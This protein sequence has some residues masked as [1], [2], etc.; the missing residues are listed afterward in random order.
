MSGNRDTSGSFV[1]IGTNGNFWSSVES[2]TN[3]WRRNLNSGNATVNRNTNDKANGFS[4]RCLKDWKISFLSLRVKRNNLVAIVYLAVV[5]KYPSYMIYGILIKDLFRA[6]YDARRNKQSKL[7]V[8]AFELE[9]ESELIR[10]GKELVD[11]TYAVGQSNCFMVFKPSRREIFAANFRDR[12]VQH[13]IFNYINP[14]FDPKFINDSYSCRVGKGTSAGI[15]RCDH[16]IRSCSQNYSQDCFILKMDLRG[17][18]MA[19]NK[20]IL[21]KELE[22]GIVEDKNY[23][24]YDKKWLLSLIRL[25]VFHD[26]TKNC[27]IKN[28]KEDWVGLPKNKS[29]FF[30]GKDRGLPIGNLT[31]QLFANIYLNGFDHYVKEVLKCKYYGRYVDDIIIVNTDKKRL[32]TLIP[33]IKNYLQ[34][35]LMLELHPKKIYLQHYKR[36]VTFLGAVIKPYRKYILNRTKGNF[37]TKIKQWNKLLKLSGNRLEEDELKKFLC[38]TNSYLGLMAQFSTFKLRK[39][40]LTKYLAPEFDKYMICAVDCGK[41]MLTKR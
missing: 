21:Y 10:L 13:L 4:V 30:S 16:F 39:K 14:I 32:V 36:G 11:G 27:K 15:K 33:I 22:K 38:S 24:R 31:S 34:N 1:N 28:K 5:K 19:I 17:Y 35:N 40:I 18:F 26:P 25:V 3:A 7:S 20:E 8:V 2:G 41:I 12:V 37:I 6:Y 23:R 9:Y 29:L